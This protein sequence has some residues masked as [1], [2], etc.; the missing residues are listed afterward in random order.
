[1]AR[2][3]A[4]HRSI[5]GCR[6]QQT[7]RSTAVAVVLGTLREEVPDGHEP[8]RLRVVISGVLGLASFA[9]L[10]GVAD[11][12]EQ[13]LTEALGAAAKEAVASERSGELL[14]GLSADDDVALV[15][16]TA[17]DG[18]EVDRLHVAL[19]SRE[20]VGGDP[21]GFDEH[22]S[23]MPLVGGEVRVSHRPV[24]R[25]VARPFPFPDVK[26][27]QIVTVDSA[28]PLLAAGRAAL[29]AARLRPGSTVLVVADDHQDGDAL[30]V[31]GLY[32]PVDERRR[33]RE[34]HIGESVA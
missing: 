22:R 28:R 27:A 20:Q 19:S 24:M 33:I 1:M 29:D 5:G 34:R 26:M 2:R 3:R 32:V 18:F 17:G 23:E 7:R 13:T 31:W 16:V 6:R 8:G 21:V 4:G 10:R 12:G 9:R 15:V 11:E 14:V 30:R 25:R